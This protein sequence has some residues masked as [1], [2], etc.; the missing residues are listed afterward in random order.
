M[1]QGLLIGIFLGVVAVLSFALFTMWKKLQSLT[2]GLP[3]NKSESV[4]SKEFTRPAISS[5]LSL[6]ILSA[7]PTVSSAQWA[8][9]LAQ[10]LAAGKTVLLID[11]VDSQP[12]AQCAEMPSL[13]PGQT[14]HYQSNLDLSYLNIKDQ[15]SL[16]QLQEYK[17]KWDNI[18]VFTDLEPG[19]SDLLRQCN[20]SLIV[21]NL[22]DQTVEQFSKGFDL[23]QKAA[24]PFAGLQIIGLD[25]NNSEQV[26]LYQLIQDHPADLLIAPALTSQQSPEVHLDKV[27]SNLSI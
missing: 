25:H 14:V 15:T 16:A 3:Q 12:I 17:Q 7:E 26:M 13:S 27:L 21:A 2:Q 24:I 22:S 20:Q 11:A 19:Q 8:W 5:S 4:V 23:I 1:D 18:V 10:K 9:A 6:A